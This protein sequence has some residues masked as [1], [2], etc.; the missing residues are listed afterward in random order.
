MDFEIVKEELPATM[1]VIDSPAVKQEMED[2]F[3][4]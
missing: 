3:L 2:P 4:P 1:R